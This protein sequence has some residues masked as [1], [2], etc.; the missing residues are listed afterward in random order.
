MFEYNSSPRIHAIAAAS[1]PQLKVRWVTQE[2][3][4]WIKKAFIEEVQKFNLAEG[5]AD[6]EETSTSGTDYFFEFESLKTNCIQAS[7]SA[8]TIECLRCLEDSLFTSSLAC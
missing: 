5:S 1:H 6:A 8:V 4:E 2:K 7:Q 3:K